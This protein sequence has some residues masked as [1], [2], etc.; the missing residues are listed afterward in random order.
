MLKCNNCNK[1]GLFE[2]GYKDH[3]PILLCYDCYYKGDEYIKEL[4]NRE[5]HKYAKGKLNLKE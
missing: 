2:V 3:K 1:E 5:W 4:Y